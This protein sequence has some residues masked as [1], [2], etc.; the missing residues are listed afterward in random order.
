VNEIPYNRGH[1]IPSIVILRGQQGVKK[2]NRTS[3]DDLRI[4][5]ALYRL[6]RGVD[7]VLSYNF[8]VNTGDGAIRTEEQCNAAKEAF[9]SIANSFH[10]VDF[11]LFGS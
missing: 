10:V 9:L 11:G 6:E 8:P 2:Y 3:V 4:F 5:V 1:G 7:I